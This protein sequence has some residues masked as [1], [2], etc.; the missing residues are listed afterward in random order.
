[1]A[2]R[3]RPRALPKE[4]GDAHEERDLWTKIV[5]ELKELARMSKRVNEL[6]AEILDEE[7]RLADGDP[8]WREYEHLEKLY[9]EHINLAEREQETLHSVVEKNDLLIALRTAT[10]GGDRG[11]DKKRGKRKL[12]DALTSDSPT[13]TTKI[14]RGASAAPSADALYINSEVAYRRPK[15]KGAEDMWI[16]CVVVNIIGGD[17]AKRRYE[18]QDP[19]PDEAGDHG[20]TYK[21]SAN[22]LIPIPRES[23][24]LPVYPVGKQVLARYPETTTFYR[25]EVMGTKRDGTCRLKFEGEEE[26][27][28]ETEVERRLVLDFGNK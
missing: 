22:A 20:K 18:V 9:E 28:K 8:S 5:N 21:A 4:D 19:E 14:A 1:M 16:Q 25:A 6:A 15:Q 10:E 26:V 27:G 2:A 23:A 12:D 3:N 17:G 13:R 24:G 7:Q 11:V